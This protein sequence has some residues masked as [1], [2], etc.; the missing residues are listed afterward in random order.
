MANTKTTG[1]KKVGAKK[2]GK[3]VETPV[4]TPVEGDVS[5]SL[6]SD[7]LTED[8]PYQEEFGALCAELDNSLSLIRALKSRVLRLEK[9][10]H[11]NHKAQAKKLRGKGSRRVRDPNAPKSGFAKEGPVSD[12]MK[13][14]LKLDKDAL[15]SRT[16][17]TKRIHQYCRDKN[18]QDP[19]D[20]RHINADANLRKLL[21]MKKS[22]DLTF[23][24]LQKFM[25][26]HFPNKDGV[27]PT[28]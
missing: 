11:K 5:A 8:S 20:K 13:K 4:E 27:Y 25:K 15:I 1:K 22:D 28:A 9:M 6:V 21:Q 7:P 12:D 26:I 23:F 24:N 18:L 2:S 10:V 16:D 17:V 19:K 14:F 3:K